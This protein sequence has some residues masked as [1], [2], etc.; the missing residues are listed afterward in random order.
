M[1][2]ISGCIGSDN[3]SIKGNQTSSPVPAPTPVPTPAFPINQ[4]STVPV[5]ISGSKFNPAEL[6]VVNSTTIEWTN[7]DSATDDSNRHIVNVSF[8]GEYF[9]SPPLKEREKWNFTFNSYG[10]FEYSC[11]NHPWM[12]HGHIT[13]Q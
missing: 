7:K 4:P 9:T 12:T 10:T 2:A 6:K 1:A 13:V 8:K 11:S 5:E 3:K